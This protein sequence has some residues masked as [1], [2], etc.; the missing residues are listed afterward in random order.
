MI[1]GLPWILYKPKQKIID[2]FIVNKVKIAD[3]KEQININ[4]EKFALWI[5][6]FNQ[7]KYRFKYR[8]VLDDKLTSEYIFGMLFCLIFN[9]EL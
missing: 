8:K 2:R 5:Y 7:T 6:K 4:N 1:V 3:L 9:I